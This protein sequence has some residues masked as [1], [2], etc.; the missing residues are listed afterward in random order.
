CG[1]GGGTAAC[2]GTVA[3]GFGGGTTACGGTSA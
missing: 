1:F 3:C 2:G